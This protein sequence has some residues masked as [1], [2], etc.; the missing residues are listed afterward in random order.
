MKKEI[1]Y[2]IKYAVLKLKEKSG[3]GYNSEET[4]FGY[5]VS[6]CY[7]IEKSIRYYPDGTNKLFYK[8]VF[9]FKDISEY[10]AN[11]YY[12]YETQDIGNE[13]IPI[14]D[15][16]RNVCPIDIVSNIFDDY[17]DASEV[18][19]EKN[20]ELKSKLISEI[21]ISLTNLKSKIDDFELLFSLRMNTCHKFEKIVEMKTQNMN[22]T[23]NQSKIYDNIYNEENIDIQNMTKG[24]YRFK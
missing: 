2:P 21:P 14:F 24:L 20:E 3:Y 7:V 19:K 17:E 1:N 11:L 9:P 22:I 13:N 4:I 12:N 8:V 10:K 6:K 16:Y 23:I 18:S 5:I 15:R